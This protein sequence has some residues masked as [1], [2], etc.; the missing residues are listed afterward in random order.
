MFYDAVVLDRHRRYSKWI[1]V[2]DLPQSVAMTRNVE[3]HLWTK[4]DSSLQGL[5]SWSKMILLDTLRIFS[6]I[7]QHQRRTC[8]RCSG[9]GHLEMSLL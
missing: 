3:L 9:T 1:P 6:D 5:C 2:H 4:T 7:A 8:R